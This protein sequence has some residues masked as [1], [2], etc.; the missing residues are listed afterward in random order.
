[1]KSKIKENKFLI[2]DTPRKRTQIS[3]YNKPS[4][5]WVVL[6]N[7]VLDITSFL[8]ANPQEARCLNGYLG[9]D[10]TLRLMEKEHKDVKAKVLS[11]K[12]MV[13]VAEPNMS[14]E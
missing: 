10:V 13:G 12:V 2:M 8:A 1:M 11:S 9:K 14:L 4:K 7:Q 6:D 3:K 5:A